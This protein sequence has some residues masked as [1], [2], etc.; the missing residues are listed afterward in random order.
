MPQSVLEGIQCVLIAGS[1]SLHY[2]RMCSL[3]TSTNVSCSI[4]SQVSSSGDLPVCSH[5]L[6]H[7]AA[8]VAHVLQAHAG[9]QSS[10][11]QYLAIQQGSL[12]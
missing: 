2:S 10:L 8:Y 9:Q 12:S 11:L 7:K 3:H 4:G 1:Q 6:P 5:Y